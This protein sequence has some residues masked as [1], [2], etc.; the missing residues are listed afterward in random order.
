[1][2]LQNLPRKN[3]STDL[4]LVRSSSEFPLPTGDDA[5][6]RLRDKRQP[7]NRSDEQSKRVRAH[8]LALVPW[9]GPSGEKRSLD[10]DGVH[11]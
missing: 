10:V 4:S 7:E 8:E 11:W 3:E 6:V 5:M 9:S 2:N 1:M